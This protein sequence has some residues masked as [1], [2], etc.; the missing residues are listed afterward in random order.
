MLKTLYETEKPWL[1]D[2]F[3]STRD[4]FPRI[5]VGFGG[6]NLGVHQVLPDVY[7][8][9]THIGAMKRRPLASEISLPG[10]GWQL[11]ALVTLQQR[12][13]FRIMGPHGLIIRA[14][15]SMA[16]HKRQ[17][18]EDVFFLSK[19]VDFAFLIFV[20][21]VIYGGNWGYISPPWNENYVY[22]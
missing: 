2:V 8:R 5:I 12:N 18:F 1:V 14:I 21:L 4:K 17:P 10:G 13:P 7:S 3:F 19:M 11:C 16:E 6:P 9:A 15:T 20:M 22:L